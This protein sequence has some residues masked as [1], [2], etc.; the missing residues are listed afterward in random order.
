MEMEI[1]LRQLAARVERMERVAEDRPTWKGRG[2]R[3]GL[4]QLP[5]RLLARQ[6]SGG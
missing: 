2:D 6:P 1:M 3:R 5:I 4:A